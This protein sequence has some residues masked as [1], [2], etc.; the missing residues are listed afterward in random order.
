MISALFVETNGVYFGLDNIDPW[1]EIRD[2][3]KYNGMN[4]VIAHPPCSRW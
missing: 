3:M 1:D 2:A 4:K